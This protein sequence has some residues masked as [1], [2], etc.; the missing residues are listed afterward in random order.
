MAALMSVTMQT[1]TFFGPTRSVDILNETL[2]ETCGSKGK[3]ELVYYK[4]EYVEDFEDQPVVWPR[5]RMGPVGRLG[6]FGDVER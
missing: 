5:V 6:S 1:V 2:A 4:L 3:A